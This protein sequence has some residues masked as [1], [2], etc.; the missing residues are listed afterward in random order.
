MRHQQATM[1]SDDTTNAS[2][3]ASQN[4][5]RRRQ[6]K[7]ISAARRMQNCNAQRAYRQRKRDR[8]KEL[9]AKVAALE[10]GNQPEL[11]PVQT[12]EAP[13][14][15]STPN[16]RQRD[17]SPP[18]PSHFMSTV[19]D[20]SQPYSSWNHDASMWLGDLPSISLG[21]EVMAQDT[22]NDANLITAEDDSRQSFSALLYNSDAGALPSIHMQNAYI[23]TTTES[24]DTTTP[25]ALAPPSLSSINTTV[26]MY[27]APKPQARKD[28]SIYRPSSKPLLRKPRLIRKWFQSLSQATRLHLTQLARNGDFKFIDIISSLLLAEAGITN[29]SDQIFEGGAPNNTE[30]LLAD[31]RLAMSPAA[32][33]SPYRNTLRI[34]RFSYFAALFTNCS[35][36]G[37]DFGS[38]L[39]ERSVSPF[40]HSNATKDGD[41][42]MAIVDSNIPPNL[43][44][45]PSQRT[46]THHPYLDTLPFPTFRRRALA[47]LAADPSLL[48]ENDLCLDLMLY[49]G[50]V[51]WGSASQNGMDHGT[52]WDCH[53]WEA[54]EWFLRKWKWLVGGQDSELWQSSRWWA[55]QRGEHI[56]M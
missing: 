17:S 4:K 23:P 5:P 39:D 54:K 33:Y 10:P 22:S 1:T 8:L 21:A 13:I 31:M 37:F 41:T 38:F 7:P 36:L 34:A 47:A 30:S 24:S 25:A 2:K 51:C 20:S 55:A 46:V 18:S 16:T 28:I 49:D 44:P 56:S 53:S 11:V 9:E 45:L 19:V 32:S 15:D 52:P 40:C 48:D 29:S 3:P 6:N 42:C 12:P 43:R 50:L 14:V 35:C 26:S 27:S